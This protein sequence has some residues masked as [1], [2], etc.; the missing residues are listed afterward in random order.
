V[1][2]T[3]KRMGLALG[4]LGHPFNPSR[5]GRIRDLSAQAAGNVVHGT[6]WWLCEQCAVFIGVACPPRI[7]FTRQSFVS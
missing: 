1:P 2:G 5:I 4:L 6:P 7:D 3:L